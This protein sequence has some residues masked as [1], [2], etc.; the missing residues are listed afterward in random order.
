MMTSDFRNMQ[1]HYKP[2]RHGRATRER[3]ILRCL[4]YYKADR[5]DALADEKELCVKHPV[6][7]FEIP[8]NDLDRAIIFY[9]A[10]FECT[11]EQVE[12]DGNAM[13]R[14][15]ASDHSGGITGALAQG[16]SYVPGKQGA[17]IYFA[18]TSITDMLNKVIRAGGRVLYPRTSIGELGWVAEF[19]D[20]EGNC[21]AW[22]EE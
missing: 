11:L 13:A 6:V 5:N 15:P 9:S 21:I 22:S 12:I 16:E 4:H 20:S 3:L 14:F 19:E 8:V 10:V 2:V 7:Y 18:T 1:L 17:R